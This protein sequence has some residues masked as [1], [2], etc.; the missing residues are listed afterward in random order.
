MYEIKPE[1]L[2]MG[3][4]ISRSL[5]W[6]DSL[7]RW[8]VPIIFVCSDYIAVLL[9]IGSAYVVRTELLPKIITLQTFSGIPDIYTYITIPMTVIF[10]MHF[11]CLYRRRLSLWQQTEK[12]F[13]I[14]IYSLVFILTIMYMTE[15]VKQ[16]SRPF[17]LALSV[18]MFA[19]L[20]FSR[21]VVKKILLAFELWQI[22]IVIIGAGKTAE[23]LLKAFQEDDSL[24]Y[25]VVGLIDDNPEVSSALSRIPIIG[26]F[27]Q[28]ENAIKKTGVGHVVIA[29]PGLERGKLVELVYRLQLNSLKVTFVPDLFEIP[30]GTL[31][32]ETLFNEKAVLLTIRNNLAQY[33]NVISKRIFDIVVSGLSFL[34]V[35]PALL[36]IAVL[37]RLDSP[38]AAIFVDKRIGKNGQ[39]FNCY[40]FRTMH[41]RSEVV[42]QE[43]LQANPEALTEWQQ[44][45]KLRSYDPRVTRLGKWL[46]KY[47]LDELPQF[48]NVL[49]GEMSLVGPRPYLP[50]EKEQM[51][52]YAQTIEKVHPGISGLWQVSGRNDL[53]FEKRLTLDCWYIRNWSLWLDMMLLAKTL[54]VVFARKG[55][56]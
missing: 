36:L 10:F 12:I 23:L 56:Y 53:T 44:Y 48:I 55:A 54:K 37:I 35:L 34:F 27:K 17:M 3:G 13:E 33:H 11:G 4:G 16:V 24:G 8:L 40:K 49:K 14:T 19:Y 52:Y 30:V 26:N 39:I 50:R 38:G 18:F 9:A 6:T 2:S 46:R 5:A 32:M 29:A 1:T 15:T 51:G 41:T 47:S 45:A 28:T 7:R 25:K 20:T 22:P 42:L 31:E 43:Y 21:H